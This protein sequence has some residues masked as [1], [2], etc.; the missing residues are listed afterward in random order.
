MTTGR[1][2]LDNLA[3]DATLSG[4][5]WGGTL[6][7]VL[8][9]RITSKPARCADPSDLEASQF[10]ITFDDKVLLTG[11][12]LGGHT[13]LLDSRYQITCYEGETE[14]L[15]LEWRDVFG[16]LYDTEQLPFEQGNWYTGKPRL[17]DIQGYA[18]HLPV[19]FPTS[20]APDSILVEL[21]VRDVA[22]ASEDF[23][24][25]YV[26]AVAALAPLWNYDWGR[27]LGISR[28]TQ[29]EVTVGGRVIKSRRTNAREH[30]VSF[31]SLTKTEAMAIYDRAML[32][33]DHPIVFDPDPSDL[34]HEFR[35]VFPAV[36]SVV[37]A[38]RQVDETGDWSITLRFTEMQG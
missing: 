6:D 25:G 1:I 23:D 34:V 10:L 38:P 31:P 8:D 33:D 19:R 3:L 18:R 30:V 21:D 16:R 29:E 37:S 2:L 11:L 14:L 26:M 22:D 12:L 5:S 17:K 36:M 13:A 20:V 24:L 15:Q 9:P 27:E 28:R 7:N 4:G 32:D 35:E